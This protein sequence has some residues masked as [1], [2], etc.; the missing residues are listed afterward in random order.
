L[1]FFQLVAGRGWG[2]KGNRAY[3]LSR[4]GAT[5]GSEQTMFTDDP[6]VIIIP[7]CF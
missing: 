4:S 1:L 2:E 6:I 3:L 7:P 5:P